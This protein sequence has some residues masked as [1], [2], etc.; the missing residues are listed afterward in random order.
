MKPLK[1]AARALVLFAIVNTASLGL[2]AHAQQTQQAQSSPQASTT[3]T[4]LRVDGKLMDA[5]LVYV[6]APVYPQIAMMA[7]VSGTVVVHAIITRDG[8]VSGVAII[9][10][11]AL[12]QRAALD[13]V[14]QWRFEPTLLN[15]EPVEVETTIPVHFNLYDT[16]P[17]TFKRDVREPGSSHPLLN[18]T[19][20][21]SAA[22]KKKDWTDFIA[23]FEDATSR[24]WLA[25]M[26]ASASDKKG[27]VTVSFAVRSDGEIDGGVS[28]MHSSGD[29][30]IDSAARR[31]IQGSAPFR[32][33]PSDLREPNINVRV[34]FAYDHPHSVTPA[35]ASQ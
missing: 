10:G 2:D 13:A 31:A 12:L 34:T 21:I 14:R 5:K 8:T 23:S 30:V 4:P 17:F 16:V 26:P 33:L 24:A 18:E 19:I 20:E 32:S 6:V 7:R 29:P 25:A 27:K 28:L 3:Q 1:Y 15:G 35:G 11:P 9:S 22:G